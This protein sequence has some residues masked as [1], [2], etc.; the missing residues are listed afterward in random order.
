[1][2]ISNGNEKSLINQVEYL[3][4]DEEKNSLDLSKCNN[5]NIKILYGIKPNSNL[6]MSVL[7]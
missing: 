2:E 7:N 3:V 5:S 6:D 4:Y 1:M